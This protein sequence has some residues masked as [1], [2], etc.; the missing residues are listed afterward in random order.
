M[1]EPKMNRRG[2]IASG[3]VCTGALAL[4]AP[5]LA[6]TYPSKPVRMIVGFAPGGATDAV[7]RL[8]APYLGEALGKP[9]IVENRPGGNGAISNAAVKNAQPD[10][11]TLLLSNSS[12]IV[13]TPHA[14]TNTG[15][16]PVTDLK[17]V[18]MFATG[19]L[20]LLTSPALK[21][22]SLEEIVARSK[23]DPSAYTNASPGI[24]SSNELAFEMFR[25]A[26]GAQIITAQY[27]GTGPIMTDLLSDRVN[28]TVAAESSAEPYIKEDSLGALCTFGTERSEFLP[29][30]PSSHELGIEGLDELMFWNGLHAPLGIPD[31]IVATLEEAFATI[32]E[33]E[34]LRK[35]LADMRLQTRLLRGEDFQKR[36]QQDWDMFGEIYQQT[37]G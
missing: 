9:V 20:V 31:E 28:M 26:T 34:D 19:R 16:N 2:F 32:L 10:G 30:V 7:A 33:N 11:H 12:F 29:D 36:V 24:G 15:V 25:R 18:A 3:L 8:V 4:G 21:G 27:T 5:A 6:A 1:T 23:D 14:A 35:R 22:M 17:H 37:H 13:A